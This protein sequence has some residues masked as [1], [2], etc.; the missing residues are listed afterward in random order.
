MIL[1]KGQDHFDFLKII[2]K[3]LWIQ[4]TDDTVVEIE[5]E[6][7]LIKID[8][9]RVIRWEFNKEDRDEVPIE[10]PTTEQERV[11]NCL[12]KHFSSMVEF[13]S[14][15]LNRAL[16]VPLPMLQ[17]SKYFSTMVEHRGR[18]VADAVFKKFWQDPEF[19][20]PS[21]LA[22]IQIMRSIPMTRSFI[23]QYQ[24]SYHCHLKNKI[25]FDDFIKFRNLREA[26]LISRKLIRGSSD[27]IISMVSSVITKGTILLL[28]NHVMAKSSKRYIIS[29]LVERF[30][31]IESA[32]GDLEGWIEYFVNR[33]SLMMKLLPF[34]CCICLSDKI[35][36]YGYSNCCHTMC[37][38][39]L[40]LNTQR[41][42]LKCPE[43]REISM[44]AFAFPINGL[45]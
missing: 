40:D 18:E 1:D 29:Q 14:F 32:P 38:S 7:G 19:E 16:Y 21:H 37:K 39:C 20:I 30:G 3:D 6:L 43:C 12:E 41:N 26:E 10:I 27:E 15:L 31:T 24:T 36:P 42:K 17:E 13:H 44:V 45:Q 28:D 9:G 4:I 22:F 23:E 2:C 8:L 35:I 34:E 25:E 33:K 11:D 5:K